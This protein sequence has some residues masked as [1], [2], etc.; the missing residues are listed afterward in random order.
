MSTKTSIA[1]QR[2]G[3][4]HDT[5][6]RPQLGFS[7]TPSMPTLIPHRVRRKLRSNLRSR[8]APSA[9]AF[10]SLNRSFSPAD[11]VGA[12]RRHHWS[13][14]DGQYLVL[15]ILAIFSLC[16]IPSPGPIVKTAFCVFIIVALILPI[17]R[18]FL[19]PSLFIWMWLISFYACGY[20]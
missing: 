15:I 13:L 3:G 16:I 6:S 10:T 14:F 1:M 18:Q 2:D 12:L 4:L 5:F 19:L 8:Q 20:A 17:S 9:A 11:T 7:W